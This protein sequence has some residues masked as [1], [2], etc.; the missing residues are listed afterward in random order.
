MCVDYRDLNKATLKDDFPLPHI[1][2]LIHF[3]NGKKY[4]TCADGMA[5]FNQ[6][7]MAITDKVKTAF[8]TEWGTFYFK[9]IPFGL[10]MLMQHIREL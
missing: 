9:V 4:Y 2:V 5:G 10:K 1:N 6:I 3:A 7:M 8:I